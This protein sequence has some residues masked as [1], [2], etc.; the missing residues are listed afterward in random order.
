MDAGPLTLVMNFIGPIVLG[1]ALLLGM[2]W[3][4]RRRNA[5]SDAATRQLYDRVEDERRRKEGN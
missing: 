2:V 3:W 1:V 5:T 4:R